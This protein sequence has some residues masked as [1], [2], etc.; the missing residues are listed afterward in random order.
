MTK[1]HLTLFLLSLVFIVSP[2]ARIDLRAQEAVSQIQG[3]AQSTASE[4]LRLERIPVAGGAELITIHARLKG[5]ET[6]TEQQ[7]VPMVSVLRDTL[8]DFTPENDRLRY[9]WP[10]TYSR[11]TLKQRL[12]GAIPFFLHEDG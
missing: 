10:L 8:G 2:L 11:P 6:D 9:V 5:L 4:I 3:T 7:W 1:N 12:A